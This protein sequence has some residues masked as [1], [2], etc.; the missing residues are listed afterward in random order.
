MRILSTFSWAI[1]GIG[2]ATI[3]AL[4]SIA[5]SVVCPHWAWNKSYFALHLYRPLLALAFLFCLAAP[6][7]TARP[8][9]QRLFVRLLAG[10]S[11]AF[12]YFGSSFAILLLCG[13]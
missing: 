9:A 7:F 11:A 5:I 3:L 12:V 13:A 8:I 10:L 2:I 6:F 1:F 4:Q